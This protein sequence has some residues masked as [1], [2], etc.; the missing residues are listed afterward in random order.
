MKLIQFTVL[1]VALLIASCTSD[2]HKKHAGGEGGSEAA[3]GDYYTCPMHPSVHSDRP[4]ACPICGMTLVKK[5]VQDH[6]A[7]SDSTMLRTISLSPRQ[8]VLANVTTVPA[9]RRTLK[10]EIIT[11]GI[12]DFAEPSLRHITMRF[13]GRLEQLSLK[14]T[15]QKVRAGD[16]VATVYSPEAISA[17]Q[18][19]ILAENSSEYAKETDSTSISNASALLNQSK[20][21]LLRWGF[22]P[23][24]IEILRRSKEVKNL[25]T[26]L[27]PITGTVVKKYVDPQQYATTGEVIYDVA[28]LSTLWMYADVYEQDMRF[29]KDEQTIQ[30]TSEAYPNEVFT[31]TVTF[32]DPV[33]NGDTRT[34]RIRTELANPEGKLKPQ[35]YVTA[36]VFVTTPQALVVPNSSVLST[37]K[38]NVVWVESMP[39]I[40]EARNVVLGARTELFQEII[41]G[42]REGEKVAATGGFLI[43]SESSL[44][45][46]SSTNQHSGHTMPGKEK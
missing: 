22:S 36:R 12:I 7:A 26:I 16:P 3:I 43:D 5:S 18:E 1:L 35:M 32:T 11:V 25:V 29:I 6:T 15:G 9:E 31:G 42:I 13:P 39:G 37:G 17:Q 46:P 28:D 33:M 23:G 41:S 27:S 21:K 20:E 10:K 45:N 34:V 24:Q 4:G 2:E 19:F 44:R 8:R 30:I 40:F 14:Y 38:R